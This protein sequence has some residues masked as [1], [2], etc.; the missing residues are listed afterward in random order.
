MFAS[1][2]KINIL[3]STHKIVKKC[4]EIL[5]NS[6]AKKLVVTKDFSTAKQLISEP[7]KATK[8]E[9]L[10]V[11]DLLCSFVILPMKVPQRSNFLSRFWKT[12][13]NLHMKLQHKV[14]RALKVL[15]SNCGNNQNNVL[16][17]CCSSSLFVRVFANV[18]HR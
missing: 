16:Q 15:N 14:E 8:R 12:N 6:L 11:L 9:V 7:T 5:M 4:L 17:R 1:F 3:T 18:K 2:S 13:K 10:V